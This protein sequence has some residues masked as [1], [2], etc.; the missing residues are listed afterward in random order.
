[1]IL[2][3]KF[4]LDQVV[5][6]IGSSIEYKTEGQCPTCEGKRYLTLYPDGTYRPGF[7]HDAPREYPTSRCP[8]CDGNHRGP[9]HCRTVWA[10]QAPSTVGKVAVCVYANH[11]EHHDRGNQYMLLRT[12]IGS[13]TVYDEERLFATADEA[14]AEVARRNATEEWVEKA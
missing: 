12:G 5:Y 2:E 8:T 9:T 11:G 4:D 13:G 1:M 10:V 7:D 3:T 14:A 6:P